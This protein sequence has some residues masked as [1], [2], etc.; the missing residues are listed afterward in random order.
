MGR[1]SPIMPLRTKK[2]DKREQANSPTLRTTRDFFPGVFLL[3]SG[4][5]ELHGTAISKKT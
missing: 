3:F 4:L 1:R 2:R 5:L